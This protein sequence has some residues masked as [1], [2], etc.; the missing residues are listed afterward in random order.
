MDLFP[1]VRCSGVHAAFLFSGILDGRHTIDFTMVTH[2]R[3][4]TIAQE[5]AGVG[6]IDRLAFFAQVT[7]R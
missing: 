3:K 1:D 6:A 7:I 5:A 2:R 4:S